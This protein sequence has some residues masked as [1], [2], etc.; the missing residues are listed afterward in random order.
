MMALLSG[1]PLRSYLSKGIVNS[2][3]MIPKS[4]S[5]PLPGNLQ[6]S[7]HGFGTSVHGKD[8]VIPEELGNKL[9]VNAKDGV[10]KSP[11]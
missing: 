11:G 5:R 8:T 7:L 3:T 10:V 1:T 6:A 2:S 9:G 4:Y